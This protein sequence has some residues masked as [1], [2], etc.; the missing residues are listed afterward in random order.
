MGMASS[1]ARL[2]SLTSRQHS[3]ELKAQVLQAQK[4][5]L[6]NDSD[7]AYDNY[8]KSLDATRLQTKLFNKDGKQAWVDASVNNLMRINNS[9]TYGNTFFVKNID[10][11]KIYLPQSVADKYE[12]AN[13]DEE[14]FLNLY[15]ITRSTE[16]DTSA[17]DTAQAKVDADIANGWDKEPKCEDFG[18]TAEIYNNYNTL[19]EVFKNARSIQEILKRHDNG[20][21]KNNDYETLM[22]NFNEIMNTEVYNNDQNLQIIFEGTTNLQT[23]QSA[24]LSSD[25]K[26][27][28]DLGNHGYNNLNG[29]SYKQFCDTITSSDV[30]YDVIATLVAAAENGFLPSSGTLT[31]AKDGTVYLDTNHDYRKYTLSY[32]NTGI[33]YTLSCNGQS[34]N[35]GTNNNALSSNNQ[36]LLFLSG[37]SYSSSITLGLKYA[38]YSRG[39]GGAYVDNNN[40]DN[41]DDNDASTAGLNVYL[42]SDQHVN[43][44][45]DAPIKISANKS[46]DLYNS[47]L[48]NA[49]KGYLGESTRANPYEY[50]VSEVFDKLTAEILSYESYADEVAAYEAAKPNY[51]TYLKDEQE[52]INAR[53]V[54]YIQY[55]NSVSG[56]YYENLF[57]AIQLSGGYHVIS[58]AQA[59][60]GDWVNSM[61]RSGKVLLSVYDKDQGEMNDYTGYN[62][63]GLQ[64]V[65]NEGEMA[66][67]DV[68]YENELD[69]IN[70]KELKISRRLSRLETERAAI[71]T[72]ID[73]IKQIRNDNINVAFKVF[74]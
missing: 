49:I 27:S 71:K 5:Q 17:I 24:S 31:N 35:L 52:L 56:P 47:S 14:R 15:G 48:K 8:V 23:A 59:K 67:A 1:Q 11:G 21:L 20:T 37:G 30:S 4:L 74:G 69:A 9:D 12:S 72:E 58:S 54:E 34:S 6:A 57:K 33:K 46:T 62:H 42:W 73:S 36:A 66:V 2:L 7:A 19:N 40:N 43:V 63:P 64:E 32:T 25:G 51:I 3:I 55:N 39:F 65:A 61:A 16:I 38:L 41:S 68:E 26:L 60:D 45:S 13:G 28:V 53:K 50:N 44:N 22:S 18:I 29:L 70:S 10:D